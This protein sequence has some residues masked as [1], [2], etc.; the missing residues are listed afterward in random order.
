MR[1][2]RALRL[3]LRLQG[4]SRFVH[5][6]Q[7]RPLLRPGGQ[8][9]GRRPLLPRV[10][11]GVRHA[12]VP[13]VQALLLP[14]PETFRRVQAGELLPA[15]L[16]PRPGARLHRRLPVRLGLGAGELDVRA[17]VHGADR[18]QRG[19]LRLLRPHRVLPGCAVRVHR[20]PGGL[21]RAHQPQGGRGP[22]PD[23]EAAARV[24]RRLL[25]QLAA[26]QRLPHAGHHRQAVPVLAQLRRP[27]PH[28]HRAVR[29]RHVRQL[30]GAAVPVLREEEGGDEGS[31]RGQ[32]GLSER[33]A[34]KVKLE[35]L[36]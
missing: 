28:R 27:R 13:A 35:N 30:A 31:R 7:A 23:G 33:G 17:G 5:G 15:R 11:D 16:L 25:P 22:Q 14:R 29:H 21:P 12:V 34:L 18:Q 1:L 32:E 2:Q 10:A 24:H 20:A 19:P 9:S 6:Q 36:M 26:A 3:R 8:H 4:P